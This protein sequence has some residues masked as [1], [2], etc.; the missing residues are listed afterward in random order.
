MANLRR[1]REPRTQRR[2]WENGR[3]GKD[4]EVASTKPRGWPRIS[5][6]TPSYNQGAYLEQCIRSVLDQDYPDLEYF[7]LDGGSSD[8]SV[9]IIKGYQDRITFWVS[10]RDGG[11]TAAINSGFQ[12]TTGD[13]VAWL[14]AD[15][16]YL[17]G[18]FASVAEAYRAAPQASFFF[19]DG[20]RVDVAGERLSNFFPAGH[21][22][23]HEAAFVF[24][25]NCILQPAAFINRLHL[26]AIGYLDPTLRYGMDSDLWIRLARQAPPVAIQ[27]VLAASREYGTT[28]T[29]TGSFARVEELRRIAEKYSGVPMTP[30]AL[31]Y[32]LDT[33]NQLAAARPDIYPARF[34]SEI[35]GFWMAASRLLGRHGARPD[36]FPVADE[37]E[38]ARCAAEGVPRVTVTQADWEARQAMLEQLSSQLTAAQQELQALRNR[39]LARRLWRLPRRVL[40]LLMRTGE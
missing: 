36:G 18:A 15:D 26:V 29:A 25:L 2:A 5:V 37:E 28:K 32:F 19:G 22:L 31:L 27:E 11:Q 13:M 1:R 4:L 34:R 33:L 12:R 8:E 23:F 38:R 17:P 35:E 6:V 16:F 7:I 24:G 3:P 39:S 20:W 14:N 10:E 9:N 30:G 40:R 21:V